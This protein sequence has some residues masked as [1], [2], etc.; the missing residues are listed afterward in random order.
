MFEDGIIRMFGREHCE[1]HIF[2]PA[3]AYA[4]STPKGNVHYHDWGITEVSFT[5]DKNR[6]FLSLSESMGKLGH[7]NRR[8]DVFKID[9]EGCEWTTHKAWLQADIR[10]VLVESHGITSETPAIEFFEDLTKAG[11]VLFSKEANTHPVAHPIGQ[12]FEW[13]FVRLAPEFL[14][15]QS[16]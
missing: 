5:D 6:R 8:I 11:F 14:N 10:Q 1:I 7:S 3:P 2:D 9:C 4:S 12:L 15:Y 13:G 16:L